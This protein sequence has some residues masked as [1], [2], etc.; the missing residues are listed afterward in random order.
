MAG[1]LDVPDRGDG[2]ELRLADLEGDRGGGALVRRLPEEGV[3]RRVEAAAR[4]PDRVPAGRAAVADPALGRAGV[5]VRRIGRA[6][7]GDGAR[8]EPET[9]LEP[10]LQ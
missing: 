2:P 8:I 9:A 10:E 1:A 7:T 3:D 6:A 5:V 4:R